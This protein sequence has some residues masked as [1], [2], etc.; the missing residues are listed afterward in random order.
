MNTG[1]IQNQNTRKRKYVVFLL[2]KDTYSVPI[3]EIKEII[4]HVY[5]TPLPNSSPF[6]TGLLNLRGQIITIFNLRRKF[7]MPKRDP[8]PMKDSIIISQ[9]GELTVGFTVDEVTAVEGISG[10]D[11]GLP[12]AIDESKSKEYVTGVVKNDRDS[13]LTLILDLPKVLGKEEYANIQNS[14]Q[15]S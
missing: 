7:G 15:V 6:I 10:E 11:I 9:I 3:S 14:Q 8:N 12:T 1:S 5:V 13:G 4:A 2:E